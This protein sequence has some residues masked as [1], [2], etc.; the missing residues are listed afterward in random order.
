MRKQIISYVNGL[1]DR[2]VTAHD[3]VSKVGYKYVYI[4]DT[5]YSETTKLTLSEFKEKYM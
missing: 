4:F 3:H 2:M 1:N 5:Y